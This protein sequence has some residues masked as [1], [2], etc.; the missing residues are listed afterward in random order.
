MIE[1]NPW[2]ILLWVVAL[3]L[4]SVPLI[5]FCVNSIFIG[6]FKAKEQH[7]GRMITTFGKFLGK[8]GSDLNEKIEA[9]KEAIMKKFSESLNKKED[10]SNAD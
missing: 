2:Q 5:V 10:T 9:N 6:Y 8:V 3:E 1:L 7:E 4:I